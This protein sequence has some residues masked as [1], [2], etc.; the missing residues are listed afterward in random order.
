MKKYNFIADTKL[1]TLKEFLKKIVVFSHEP[2]KPFIDYNQCLGYGNNGNPFFEEEKVPT[3]DVSTYQRKRAMLDNGSLL[4]KLLDST[5]IRQVWR[6]SAEEFF[7][8]MIVNDAM[9]FGIPNYLV[10]I[11]PR[12]WMAVNIEDFAIYENN[13]GKALLSYNI[14][15]N[16]AAVMLKM[17]IKEAA[18]KTGIKL[19]SNDI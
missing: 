1:I 8:E 14:D 4:G 10:R 17:T 11:S 6:V 7:E 15:R 9:S 16:K 2:N 12:T 5:S 18:D 19:P 13:K 3:E